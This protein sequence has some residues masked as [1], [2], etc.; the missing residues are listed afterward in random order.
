MAKVL[1]ITGATGKQGGSV[2]DALLADPTAETT[3]VIAAVTRNPTSKGAQA[4]AARSPAIKIIQGDFNDTP[5]LFRTA[6]E[7]T[8]APVWGVFSV[9]V[10]MGKGQSHETE[11]RYGKAMVDESLKQ[12]VKQFVYTSVDRGGD[13]KS[14]TN[15]TPVPHFISKHNVELYLRQQAASKMGWTILRPV[16]FMDNIVP[17]FQTKVFMAA[18]H[19]ALQE[20]PLQLIA[21]AD[22]G[23]F[24]AQAFLHPDDAK[25]KNK[26]VGLAGDELSFSQLDA[27][28]KKT[29]GNG[30][31]V[32]FGVLGKALLWG[33]AEMGSMMKWFKT[34]GYGADVRNLRTVHPG[35]MNFETWMQKKSAF[36]TK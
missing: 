13:E 9:Q 28:F 34:D 7:I 1:L 15:P 3:F 24:A 25:Y 29:T 8:K 10:P 33:V 17:G 23:W 32:T 16:A 35:L 4:L 2:I 21:T 20:K 22:I 26:A 12:G 19:S 11:E 36:V 27:V 31:P 18:W 6:S 14:W 5:A 30:V